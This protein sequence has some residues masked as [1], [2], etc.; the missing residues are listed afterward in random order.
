MNRIVTGLAEDGRATIVRRDELSP[1]TGG[2]PG[3]PEMQAIW[4]TA[5]PFAI[6][7]IDIELPDRDR[8][9]YPGAGEARFMLSMLPGN[10]VTQQHVTS[11]VDYFLVVSGELWLVMEDGSEARLAQ[12]D[13]VVQRGTVHAWENRSDQPC[14]VAFVMLGL[15]G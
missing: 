12:G 14:L 7:D 4:S 3:R 13:S 5:T 1:M 2:R 8:S 15:D 10:F 9:G 6:S 11:T